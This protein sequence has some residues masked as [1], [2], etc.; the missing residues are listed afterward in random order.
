MVFLWFS[1][2]LPEGKPPAQSPPRD[3]WHRMDTDE[4]LQVAAI[5]VPINLRYSAP[6]VAYMVGKVQA[7]MLFL[8]SSDSKYETWGTDGNCHIL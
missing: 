3:I 5:S 1:Y 7:K 6:E 4:Q 8:H 2:G